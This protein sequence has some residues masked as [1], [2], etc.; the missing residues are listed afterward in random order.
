[1]NRI[2]GAQVEGTNW[3]Q[4]IEIYIELSDSSD[5][6]MLQ[7]QFKTSNFDTEKLSLELLFVDP[8]HISYNPEPETL[9]IKL[10][11][12]R[13]PNGNLIVEEQEI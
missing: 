12:F 8:D 1:M 7:F 4:G 3:V 10:I 2:Q 11:D 6:D 5:P 13:D 9:I